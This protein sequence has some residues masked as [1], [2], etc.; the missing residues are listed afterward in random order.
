MIHALWSPRLLINSNMQQFVTSMSGD[1]YPA[2]MGIVPLMY[3]LGGVFPQYLCENSTSP[4]PSASNIFLSFP[5]IVCS[6]ASMITMSLSPSFLHF[7]HCAAKSLRNNSF[8]PVLMFLFWQYLFN[9]WYCV[10]KPS[11]LP[12][13]MLYSTR[14]PLCT[15]GRHLPR[16][17]RSSIF[18][19]SCCLVHHAWRIESCA[20]SRRC[21]CLLAVSWM[22]LGLRCCG[23]I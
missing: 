9:C 6:L 8:G 11:G 18:P 7:P 3:V 1:L 15:C 16:T 23:Q 4:D 14:L 10:R 13:H 19:T 5:S 20:P 22:Y 21:Q 2:S 12:L 17:R